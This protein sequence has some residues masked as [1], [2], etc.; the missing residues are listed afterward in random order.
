MF[1]SCLVR[2]GAGLSVTLARPG[3]AALVGLVYFIG[4]KGIWEIQSIVL[5][6]VTHFEILRWK[7]H[8]E[9]CFC[10]KSVYSYGIPKK[11]H[12]EP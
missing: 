10:N 3:M 9:V 12:L 8:V 7:V 11:E 1:Y 4:F 6:C 2:Q 5:M